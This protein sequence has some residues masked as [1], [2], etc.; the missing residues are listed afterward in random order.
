MVSIIN[1]KAKFDYYF[2]ETYTAGICLLGSEVKAIRDSR[3]SMVDAFCFFIDGELWIKSLS[4]TPG[5]N[6]F[7]HEPLRDR[8]LLLKKKELKRLEKSLDKGITI[9]PT[10]IFTSERNMI[11]VEIALA[12]GKKSYDKRETI[13]A[14]EAEREI[15]RSLA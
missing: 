6:S 2:L 12:K 15:S 13:K 7:Q 8:K 4:I 14:R 11:K 1:R 9:I 10:R 5:L 3:A